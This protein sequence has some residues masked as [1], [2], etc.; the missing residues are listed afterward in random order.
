MSRHGKRSE[1]A[2][3]LSVSVPKEIKEEL[4]SIAK[5]DGRTLSN[6]IRHK[7]TQLV[8]AGRKDAKK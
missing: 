3:I 4:T 2:A 8:M 1:N 7:L 6:L 5:R